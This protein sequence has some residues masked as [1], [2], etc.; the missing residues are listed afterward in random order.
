MCKALC[1]SDLPSASPLGSES[2]QVQIRDH[3]PLAPLTEG[4]PGTVAVGT[5]NTSLRVAMQ[6]P[7][8]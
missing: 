2:Q 5:A 8:G 6:P 1:T 7:Q 4:I 3:T